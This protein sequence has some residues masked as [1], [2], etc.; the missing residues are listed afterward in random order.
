MMCLD[1][2]E[3]QPLPESYVKENQDAI[4]KQIVM[5]GYRLA[6]LIE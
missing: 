3:N 4:E 5:G 6:Y 2:H 1:I